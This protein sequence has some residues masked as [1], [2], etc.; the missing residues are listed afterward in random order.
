M[1][2]VLG[3]DTSSIVATV[4]VAEETRLIAEYYIESEKNHSEKLIPVIKAMLEECGLQPTCIDAVAV[5]KGPGSFTGLRIGVVTAKGFA[6]ASNIPIIGI[7]TL[8]GLA[9]NAAIFGGLICP[10][11]NA[12]RGN[13]Y[14]A[15]FRSKNGGIERLSEYKVLHIDDV[16]KRVDEYSEPVVFLGDGVPLFRS[17]IKRVLG[18]NAKIAPPM[19]FMPRA[20][21]IA[22]LGIEGLKRGEGESAFS[23]MPFYLR[24]SQAEIQL[25]RKKGR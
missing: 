4:A 13:V 24:K 5:A 16:L 17:E 20:S 22:A 7:N 14:T 11:L 12:L 10:I 21:S 1:K 25:E 15:L 19:L 8:D 3:I 2:K 23:L 9:Y 18:N 6:F